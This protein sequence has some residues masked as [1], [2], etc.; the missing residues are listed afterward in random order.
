MDPREKYTLAREN[1]LNGL[2]DRIHIFPVGPT[3][4]FSKKR[5]DKNPLFIVH[6]SW[7][8]HAQKKSTKK[9]IFFY[10]QQG[11]ITHLVKTKNLN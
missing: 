11:P 5:V 7:S 10:I 8:K 2:G 3:Y 1:P 9:N 4:I 6:G